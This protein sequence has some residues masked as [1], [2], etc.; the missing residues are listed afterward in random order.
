MRKC[1]LNLTSPQSND[2]DTGNMSMNVKKDK[3]FFI[4]D[5]V[6]YRALFNHGNFNSVIH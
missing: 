1:S 6:A 3:Y 2:A 4:R 5:K